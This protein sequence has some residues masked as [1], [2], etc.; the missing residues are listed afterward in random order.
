VVGDVIVAVLLIVGVT[1]EL[2]C[3][4][5]V[6]VMRGAMARLHYVSPASVGALLIGVAIAVREGFSLIA[7]KALLIGVFFVLT[8]P[9][10]AHVTARAARIR[11]RGELDSPAPEEPQAR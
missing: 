9:V 10:L 6:V 1:L 7:N 8:A 11:E 3:V 2:F 4:L 5:G